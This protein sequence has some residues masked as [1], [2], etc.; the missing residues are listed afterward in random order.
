MVL[1][2]H[3]LLGLTNGKVLACPAGTVGLEVGSVRLGGV[4]VIG[5]DSY[6]RSRDELVSRFVW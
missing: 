6:L 3:Q 2:G 5:D 1:G 4:E